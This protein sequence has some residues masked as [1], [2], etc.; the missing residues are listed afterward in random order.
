MKRSIIILILVSFLLGSCGGYQPPVYQQ[1][2]PMQYQQPVSQDY[3]VMYGPGGQ[4]MVRYNQ[5]GTSLLIDY[6]LFQRYYSNGGWGAVNNYYSTHRSDFRPYN[7]AYSSWTTKN[8]RGTYNSPAP[9][10]TTNKQSSTSPYIRPNSTVPKSNTNAGFGTAN[11]SKPS[12]GNN[13]GFGSR[14]TPTPSRSSSRSSGGFG[15]RK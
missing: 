1:S 2:L 13:G 9:I 4:Q 6:L 5:G 14:T 8:V 15:S 3:Q 10:T 11:T 12:T 7:S